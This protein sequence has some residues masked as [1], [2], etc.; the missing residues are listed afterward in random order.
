MF[1]KSLD[2]IKECKRRE[3][4]LIV[5]DFARRLAKGDK[6][7]DYGFSKI[8]T[9]NIEKV[10]VDKE[11]ESQVPEGIPKVVTEGHHIIKALQVGII[12]RY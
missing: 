9:N 12:R 3:I 10:I 1:E 2:N 8:D 4:K 11:F 6:L 7:V 5:D